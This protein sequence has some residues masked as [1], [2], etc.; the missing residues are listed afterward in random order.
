MGREVKDK[1]LLKFL[2]SADALYIEAYQTRRYGI[3]SDRFSQQAMEGV[4]LN[5][6][7]K[8]ELRYFAE[9]HYRKNTWE[10]LEEDAEKLVLLKT[11]I[12]KIIHVSLLK[13]MKA[14]SDYQE[15]WTVYK[16]GKYGYTVSG[17][18][19]EVYI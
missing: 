5:V 18:G 1:D 14:S 6:L 19:Q 2:E 7:Y 8:G 16:N 10:I 12:Y 11:Q 4:N 3:L 13:T 17:I 9:K 15:E